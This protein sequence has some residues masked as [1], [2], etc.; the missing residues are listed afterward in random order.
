MLAAERMGGALRAL[1]WAGGGPRQ[2][3]SAASRTCIA[4]ASAVECT[5]TEGMPSSRQARWMRSA[6]SPRLAMRIFWNKRSFQ[7]HQDFAVFY[8]RAVRDQDTHNSAGLRCFN[9]VERLHRFN[10]QKRFA[11]TYGLADG[12]EGRCTRFR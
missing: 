9:L 5:A 2:T 12:N 4:S 11:G 1:A 7:N 3:L 8:R 10:Q 6:I